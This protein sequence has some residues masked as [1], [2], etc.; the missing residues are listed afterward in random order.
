MPDHDLA[1]KSGLEKTSANTGF[2]TT[3]VGSW[4]IAR[5]DCWWDPLSI[6]ALFHSHSPVF[7]A[8]AV[9]VMRDSMVVCEANDGALGDGGSQSEFVG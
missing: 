8:L 6:T 2:C 4:F 3:P 9:I 1:V 5:P 7:L